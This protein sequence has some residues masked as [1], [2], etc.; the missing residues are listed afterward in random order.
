[1]AQVKTCYSDYASVLPSS[2]L[3][4]QLQGLN[5]MFLLANSKI[6]EFHTELELI[7]VGEFL[8]IFLM[9]CCDEAVFRWINGRILSFTS[10]LS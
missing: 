10:Q 7:Q 6:A 2:P 4:F 8:F 9:P 1:M 5:L 3:Q